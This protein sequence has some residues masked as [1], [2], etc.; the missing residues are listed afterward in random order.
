MPTSPRE[1]GRCGDSQND[2]N[3]S[4]SISVLST[5]AAEPLIHVS[6]M[7]KSISGILISNTPRLRRRVQHWLGPTFSP[8]LHTRACGSPMVEVQD[9]KWRPTSVPD[10]DLMPIL[11]LQ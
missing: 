8:T 4:L 1:N 6:K 11:Q 7:L 10:L 2:L 5:A 3:A 9:A